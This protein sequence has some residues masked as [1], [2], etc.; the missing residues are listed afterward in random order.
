MFLPYSPLHY[1]QQTLAPTVRVLIDIDYVD[2]VLATADP[3][4]KIDLT[5]RLLVVEQHFE[6]EVLFGA[7]IDALHHLSI[8][9][10]AE[11]RV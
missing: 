3:P 6:G 1:N 5:T 2:N 4:M 8:D 11:D 7:T 9:A 10:Q